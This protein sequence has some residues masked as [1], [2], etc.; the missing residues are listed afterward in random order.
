[1]PTMRVPCVGPHTRALCGHTHKAELPDRRGQRIAAASLTQR[2]ESRW[3]ADADGRAASTGPS[4][5][6]AASLATA[7]ERVNCL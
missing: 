2:Q 5:H 4:A 1:M 6:P 3:P 7:E